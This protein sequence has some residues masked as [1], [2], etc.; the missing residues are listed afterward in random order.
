MIWN[1]IYYIRYVNEYL[2]GWVVIETWNHKKGIGEERE[3]E[4]KNDKKNILIKKRNFLFLMKG[5]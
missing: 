5:K 2:G 3:I 1:S 4:R